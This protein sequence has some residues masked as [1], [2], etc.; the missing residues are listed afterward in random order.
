MKD[1]KFPARHND[2]LE[3]LYGKYIYE[4]EFNPPPCVE[5]PAWRKRS[6]KLEVEE[7]ESKAKMLKLDNHS[8]EEEKEKR[9]SFS[10]NVNQKESDA[11][12]S[13]ISEESNND[14]NVSAKW[15]SFDKGKL[16]IYTA[17]F[18]Q[19]RSKVILITLKF[20]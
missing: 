17:S 20:I 13:T 14:S 8:E 12:S 4:I 16:L 15:E 9:Q 11:G 1:V 5:H 7:T 3:L 19:S 18:I 2:R 6:R 10:S